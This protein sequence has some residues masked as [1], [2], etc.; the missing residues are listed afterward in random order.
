[1]DLRFM[2]QKSFFFNNIFVGLITEHEFRVE[3][4]HKLL[5]RKISIQTPFYIFLLMKPCS[6][7]NDQL[8]KSCMGKCFSHVYLLLLYL[9]FINQCGNFST[10]INL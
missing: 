1:M 8:S 6:Y 4:A 5:G 10:Q 7:Q 3:G 2:L 9:R